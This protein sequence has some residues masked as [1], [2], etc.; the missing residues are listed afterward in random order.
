MTLEAGTRFGPYEIQSPLGAGGMGEV[1]RARDTRLGR[2]VAIKVLPHAM[3]AAPAALERFSREARAVAALNHPN[4]CVIYDIGEAADSTADPTRQFIV[5][6]LLEGETLQQ[7]LARG[8]LDLGAIVDTGLALADALDVAHGKGI[9]H[10]DIKPAN[11][12]LTARGPKMLD[13]GLAK[14]IPAGPAAGVAESTMLAEALLTSPGSTVGTIAYMSPEQLRGED[15][16][17]RSDLFSLGLV[18]YE[19]ATGRRAFDGATSAVISAGILHQSPTPP[20]QLRPDLPARLEDLMGKALE[21]DRDVR[22]QSAAELRADLKRLKREIDSGAP[23]TTSA[24]A[25]SMSTPPAMPPVPMTA[26][27]AAT[28]ATASPAVPSSSDAQV[29]VALVKRH[30]GMVLAG[31]A[32]VAAIAIVATTSSSTARPKPGLFRIWRSRS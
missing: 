32:A 3:V 14:T 18:L 20:R 4:I 6:E 31:L 24:P 21:K 7:R 22:S 13:F 30:R 25:T 28:S 8:P 19:M 29:A 27:A 23:T 16:D 12:F 9:M 11:V 10:R 15:V 17:A 1:Y 5:M 2:D 26:S